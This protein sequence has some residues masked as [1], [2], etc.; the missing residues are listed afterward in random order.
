MP[1]PT[2][3][4]GQ[5][6]LP[7]GTPAPAFNLPATGGQTLKLSDFTGKNLVIVFYTKD[8]TP[9]CTRQLC[10]LRDD[11]G[12]FDALNTAI[13]ASNPGSLKSH[14][15][16]AA[17][18]GYPFPILVDA[19]RSMATDYQAL[20]EAGGQSIQRTV[21][22]VDAQGVIRYARQGLPNNSELL[23]AIRAFSTASFPV[24]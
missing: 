16:F 9:G 8:Q 6:P 23:D 3:S 15:N 21:Y 18:Q 5:A 19:A 14:E 2:P 4:T 7:V 13:L 24:S 17:R 22:I 11:K 1:T 12:A 20:K 10:A